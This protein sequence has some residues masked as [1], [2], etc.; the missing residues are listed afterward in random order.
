MKGAREKMK[1]IAGGEFTGS[2]QGLRRIF[3][4]S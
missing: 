4:P 1:I 3:L 2:K